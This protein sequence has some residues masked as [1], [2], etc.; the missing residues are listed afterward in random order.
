MSCFIIS[1]SDRLSGSYSKYTQSETDID[2]QSIR[3]YLHYTT[4]PDIL[5]ILNSNSVKPWIDETAVM[6][7]LDIDF[8]NHTNLT[9]MKV[10]KQTLQ[11]AG[12]VIKEEE[13]ELEVV[14]IRDK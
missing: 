4:V 7:H 14:V 8:P 3:K 1:G 5:E 9:D 11:T 10:I 12:F 13:R 2:E 6:Q